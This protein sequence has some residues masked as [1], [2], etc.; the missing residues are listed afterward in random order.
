[1][2]FPLGPG[3]GRSVRLP[4]GKRGRRAHTGPED[5]DDDVTVGRAR[6]KSVYGLL[7]RLVCPQ[8]DRRRRVVP[9]DEFKSDALTQVRLLGKPVDQLARDTA[10]FLNIPRRG[11]KYAK[12]GDIG[13]SST[14]GG[15]HKLR[16]LFTL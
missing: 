12:Q 16:Y 10:L 14:V 13:S 1:M 2:I 9:C 3:E 7:R 15:R 5:D 4:V 8:R 6:P 11:Q